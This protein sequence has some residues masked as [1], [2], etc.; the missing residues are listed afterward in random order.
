MGYSSSSVRPEARSVRPATNELESAQQTPVP[1][2]KISAAGTAYT[3]GAMFSSQPQG[4]R[5]K[6]DILIV[7]VQ[8]LRTEVRADGRSAGI[9]GEVRGESLREQEGSGGHGTKTRG[10]DSKL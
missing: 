3:K 6:K 1:F 10:V 5:T 8:F 9:G 7:A 4:S 2:P